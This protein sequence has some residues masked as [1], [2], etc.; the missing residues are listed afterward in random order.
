MPEYVY[1]T[2]PPGHTRILY[3]EPGNDGDPLH[4]SLVPHRI[5]A[6]LDYAALSYCWGPPIFSKTILL[7]ETIRITETLHHALCRM[8]RDAVAVI[9]IWA[10]A[11]C[12][13]QDSVAERSEQVSHTAKVYA[14]AALVFVD[15]G[16]CMDNSYLIPDF[17]PHVTCC[18]GL[19]IRGFNV[20]VAP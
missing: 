11:I 15:W 16:P 18:L 8:R 6:N 4:G 2:L 3:L 10:G 19:S 17:L 12:I 13:N 5:T 20:R 9:E 7:P 14:K 1:T